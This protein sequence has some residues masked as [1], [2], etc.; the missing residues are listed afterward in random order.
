MIIAKTDILCELGHDRLLKPALIERALVANEQAKYY[1]TLLQNARAH[2]EEPAAHIAELRR[3][4]VAAGVDD[5]ALDAVVAGAHKLSESTYR[6]A[7]AADLLA[8][9]L[10]AV[11]TMI[12]PVED[13]EAAAFRR[14]L[15]AHADLAAPDDVLTGDA[16]DA[17]TSADR[18]TGDTLHLLVMDV[19]KAL[20]RQQA[21]IA[22][23]TV[24]GAHV[25]N[26]SEE[27]KS[28]VRAFMGGSTGPHR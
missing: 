24:D 18:A 16:I 3:E 4:R 15:A 12:A 7:S 6:I 11:E 9:I 17:L 1:L 5:A 26:L 10:A 28:S 23:E 25:Y 21:A 22:S 2:A 14:R 13:D 27:G 8:R 19:H 20:N